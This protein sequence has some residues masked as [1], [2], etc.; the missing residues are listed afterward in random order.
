L[1]LDER[2]FPKIR[3]NLFVLF[4][5]RHGIEAIRCDNFIAIKMPRQLRGTERARGIR[6]L[7]PRAE[8]AGKRDGFDLI[9]VNPDT[10]PLDGVNINP[11]LI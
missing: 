11:W 10:S 5:K 3:K 8:S 2:L 7:F 9:L 6:P 1:P 4:V